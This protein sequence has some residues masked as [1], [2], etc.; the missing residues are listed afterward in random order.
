MTTLL[1]IDK[2]YVLDLN[3]KEYQ[4]IY[5]KPEG[6]AGLG[7]SSIVYKARGKSGKGNFVVIKEFYPVI[8]G[9]NPHNLHIN[10]KEDGSVCV[11]EKEKYEELKTQ[12]KAR[13]MNEHNI[14]DKLRSYYGDDND[15]WIPE[16]KEPVEANNTI[17]TIIVTEKG[18]IL[19]N[20]IVNGFFIDKNFI[21]ICEYMLKIL[22]A[23]KHV[24]DGKCLHLDVAVDN[25]FFS[26]SGIAKLIDYNSAYC[27]G[28][29]NLSWIPSR[30][31][32]Y[33]AYEL[34]H[35]KGMEHLSCKTDFFSVTAVFFQLLI[36]R[37]PEGMDWLLP[38]RWQSKLT[39]KSGYL[40]GATPELIEETNKFLKKGLSRKPGNRFKDIEEMKAEIETLKV[41]RAEHVIRDN[42]NEHPPSNHFVGRESKL[43]EIDDKLQEYGFVILVG[44]GG[45]GKSELSRKFA[46]EGK[47][48]KI[49][50][51]TFNEN[52]LSTIANSI[53]L[54]NYDKGDDI[55]KIKMSALQN[56][57]EK[58]LIIV[59]NYNVPDD[60]YILKFVTHK[61]KV[62]FT[63]RVTP[64]DEYNE[65]V[66]DVSSM[67]KDDL[68]DL[69]YAYYAPKDKTTVNEATVNDIIKLVQ[70]HTMTVMLIARAMEVDEIEPKDM[71]ERLKK[72]LD[73]QLTNFHVKKDDKDSNKTMYGHIK[74]LFNMAEIH[75]KKDYE[76][77]M[78][79]MAIVP[80]TGMDMDTFYDWTA[81]RERYGSNEYNGRN[82]SDL[83]ELI[84]RGWIQENNH[85]I[86]L[87]SV[88]SEVANSELKPDS[89]KCA[90][91]IKNMIAFAKDDEINGDFRKLFLDLACKRICDETLLTASLM[92]SY[93]GIGLTMYVDMDIKTAQKYNKKAL[94]IIEKISSNNKNSNQDYS[95][96]DIIMVAL[97]YDC[98]IT[99][100]KIFANIDDYKGAIEWFNRVLPSSIIGKLDHYTAE[101]YNDI[102][103]CYD[104]RGYYKTAIDWYLK[105]LNIFEKELGKDNLRTA[106]VYWTIGD[107]YL[108]LEMYHEALD[109]YKKALPGFKGM[110]YI[111]LVQD[112]MSEA[113]L[114]LNDTQKA[115]EC[116][117]DRLRHWKSLDDE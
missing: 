36:G 21:D 61:Y 57:D 37:R 25:I 98:Y 83:K 15:P 18:N 69:F 91:L 66:I 67:E 2:E 46:S 52:L 47:Y 85:A 5:V 89:T 63:S 109:F 101:T 35:F 60:D 87:H 64:L 103:E 49:Q 113:Y 44:M 41:L 72:G 53:E 19:S 32:G 62:I 55:F 74:T 29:Q 65:H 105:A 97:Y 73:T 114:K 100:G 70:G 14:A 22:E 77:I 20:M 43:K 95:Y 12:A 1:D 111:N 56:C 116:H 58:T 71:L 93:A 75:S 102:G 11:D 10:R 107:N 39:G 59:D 7:G 84:S 94:T 33:S 88:I 28:I 27:D 4:L 96:N 31:Y 79:N 24:H 51:V 45:T 54:D 13:A 9:F 81:L 115:R 8:K 48:D 6:Y 38:E 110:L 108:R 92:N 50:F 86:S 90:E 68:L 23:L 78:T 40:A 99:M 76:F 112:H 3:G 34:V 42:R 82:R 30:K 26:T 80:Y 106:L 17:Y 117:E 16:Y 104:N